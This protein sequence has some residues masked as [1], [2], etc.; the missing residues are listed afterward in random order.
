M[1]WHELAEVYSQQGLIDAAEFTYK[2]IARVF[3]S[4]KS[5][6][7]VAELQLAHLYIS[8]E[9]WEDARSTMANVTKLQSVSK[10]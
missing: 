5:V 7:L 3:A 8:H 9:K 4:D 2:H 10:P 1:F 6:R